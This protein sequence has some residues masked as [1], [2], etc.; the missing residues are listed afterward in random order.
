MNY[1]DEFNKLVKPVELG[2]KFESTTAESVEH[3]V[4]LI[5]AKNKPIVVLN[6]ILGSS[7]TYQELRKI[8]D[9]IQTA[10][11]WLKQQTQPQSETVETTEKQIEPE[12][13][14][15]QLVQP[16]EQQEEFVESNNSESSNT[17][18]G[19]EE[20]KQEIIIPTETG[21]LKKKRF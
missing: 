21:I 5:D 16:V 13:T 14:E 19:E 20:S 15:A 12:Q 17:L 7:L 11:Y 4:A 18:D 6:S 1:L 3:L 2:A 9:R 10:A 8:F